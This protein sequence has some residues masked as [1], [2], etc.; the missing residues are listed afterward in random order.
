MTIEIPLTK[1]Y[2]TI[3]DNEDADLTRVSWHSLPSGKNF[4]AAN[5]RNHK[6]TLMHRV[7]LERIIGRGLL[8]DEYADHI[9]GNGLNNRRSNIRLATA[10]QNSM[11]QKRNTQNTTGFKGVSFSKEKQLFR[12]NITVQKRTKHL[13]YFRTAE[14]AHEAYKNAATI[15][16]G[17][18]ARFN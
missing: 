10:S 2:T 1:N 12:A 18:F 5:R 11:N 16:F 13:G 9:D 4:Y 17:E 8:S 3:I 7:I 15:Y 6:T 14:E